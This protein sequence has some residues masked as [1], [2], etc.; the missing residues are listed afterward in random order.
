MLSGMEIVHVSRLL[1]QRET[2]L[3][4]EGKMELVSGLTYRVLEQSLPETESPIGN[5]IGPTTHRWT[6]DGMIC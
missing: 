6:T 4:T 5:V 2:S 3:K 1:A